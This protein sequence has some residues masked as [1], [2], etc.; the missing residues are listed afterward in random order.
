M[1]EEQRLS[2]YVCCWLGLMLVTY[3]ALYVNT[4]LALKKKFHR[5]FIV[6]TPIL[7]CCFLGW[8]GQ[9][10]WL[11]AAAAPF[12]ACFMWW[13]LKHEKG[14]F[15]ESC[16]AVLNDPLAPFSKQEKCRKCGAAVSK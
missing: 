15:C 2:V 8:A 14:T 3:W 10:L 12:A 6:G 16:S 9:K 1:N 13:G 4:N 11:V 5:A 7:F